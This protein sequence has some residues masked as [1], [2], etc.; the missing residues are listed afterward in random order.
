VPIGRAIET[1]IPGTPRNWEEKQAQQAA[2]TEGQQRIAKG[3]QELEA[4]AN[5]AAF[6]TPE[7]RRAY[8]QEHPDE[9]KGISDFEKNDFVLQGK[10]P[11]AEGTLTGKT[12]EERTLHDL[13][14]GDNGN[15]RDRKSTRLNSSH[16]SIS[17]AVSCLNK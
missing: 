5:K 17:Y 13:M 10:F 11:Q 2:R 4:G 14:T 16:G 8:M 7:K 9:F 3:Q 12:P 1:A 15:A 6:D